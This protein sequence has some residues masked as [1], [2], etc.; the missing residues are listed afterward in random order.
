AAASAAVLDG[1]LANLREGKSLSDA[2]S[3]YTGI[4][5]Q[6]Y[7][8]GVLASERTGTLTQTLTRFVS[9]QLQLDAVKKKV[10]SAS[11]YPVLLTIIGMLVTLFLLGYV[12]P[13]FSMVLET[14]GRDTSSASRGLLELGALIGRHQGLV[15]GSVAAVLVFSAAALVQASVRRELLARIV[16]LPVLRRFALTLSLARFY[17]TSALLLDAGI[18]LVR[19]LEMASSLLIPSVADLLPQALVRVRAGLPLSAALAGTPLLTPIAESL[20]KV[21]ERSGKLGEMMERIARF[22]DEELARQV[23]WFT[24]LFEPILM[25][26]IGLVIGMV[27]VLMYMPIFDL[28]GNLQ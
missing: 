20:I 26:V 21:G 24:R 17:R 23:D 13:K 8:A 18:P 1:L 28:V 7:I 27:V 25:A 14:A 9:Y 3:R 15:W 22:L 5:P 6:I 19:A 11:I 16:A 2:L 10:V 12:V 4:F